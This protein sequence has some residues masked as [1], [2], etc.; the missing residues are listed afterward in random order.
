MEVKMQNK[1]IISELVKIFKSKHKVDFDTKRGFLEVE[2]NLLVELI[3]LGREIMQKL[4]EAHGNGNEGSQIKLEGKT[5][6]NNGQ[7]PRWVHCL[8]GKVRFMRTYYVVK[9]SEKPENKEGNK[10][11]YIPLDERLSLAKGHT[12]C[13]LYFLSQFT[14]N[15]VY[16]EG[17]KCF[18]EIF[19]ADGIDEISLKKSMDMTNDLGKEIG[20]L[21]EKEKEKVYSHKPIKKD[22]VIKT[23]MAVSTDATKTREK[24][25]DFE[26]EEGKKRYETAFKDAKIASVSE[27]VWNKEKEEASCEKTTYVAAEE[28]A[29]DFFPKIITEMTKRSEDIEEVEVVFLGDGAK[30]IWDRV[31]RIKRGKVTQVLDFYHASEHL[32]DVCKVLYGEGTKKY[33]EQFSVW[34]DKLYCGKITQIISKLKSI[35]KNKKAEDKKQVLKQVAYFQENAI[36]MRYNVFRMNK[37][38]IGSGTIE[39]ACKNVIGGRMKQGGMIWSKT[40][41][42]SMLNIRASLK[43]NRLK[44]DF[45]QILNLEAA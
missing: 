38:P 39:S 9:K 25:R 42:D 4:I 21:R 33:K 17:V 27:V 24:I 19:R 1:E 44:E 6:K 7:K 35:A 5:Y 41:T 32:S 43:S 23:V 37:L 36:R 10:K 18:N 2:F 45:E 29:E 12:P 20:K 15:N 31:P 14:A 28:H 13:C 22:T 11:C 30:W 34:K 8:F 26:D 3:K 16:S 40:G